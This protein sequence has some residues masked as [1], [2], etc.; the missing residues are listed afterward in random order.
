MAFIFRPGPL[1]SGMPLK[2]SLYEASNLSSD[3]WAVIAMHAE[4]TL[5]E[6]ERVNSL[7]NRAYWL[8]LLLQMGDSTV[9]AQLLAAAHKLLV[10]T[11]K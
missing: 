6:D 9:R 7:R 1:D 5:E 3:C 4:L 2:Y 11:N 10:C 8:L